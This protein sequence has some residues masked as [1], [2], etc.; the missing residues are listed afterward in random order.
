M[1]HINNIFLFQS[2]LFTWLATTSNEERFEFLRCAFDSV[3]LEE[4]KGVQRL[5]EHSRKR[6]KN[7]LRKEQ[8][9]RARGDGDTSADVPVC[10]KLP[11]PSEGV[12]PWWSEYDENDIVALDTEMVSLKEMKGNKHIVRAAT[13]AVVRMSDNKVLY[14]VSKLLFYKHF[15]I[16]LTLPC[17]L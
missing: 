4:V 15:L 14:N 17:N 3:P 2:E 1:F 7:A 10:S 12:K 11:V 5:I 13:V 9:K 16:N 6:K 8:E